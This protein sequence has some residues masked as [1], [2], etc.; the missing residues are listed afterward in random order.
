MSVYHLNRL[1]RPRSVGLVGASPRPGSLGRIV[2]AKLREARFD[3]PV[4][5]VNPKHAEIDGSRTVG[6]ITQL[7]ETPDVVV[8]TAP[9][10]TVPA[11]LSEAGAKGVS[12]AVVISAGLGH[13]PDRWPSRRGRRRGRTGCASWGRTDSA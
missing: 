3:G 10:S 8:V 5:V 11:I 9:A 4:W 7:E 6:S 13:G 12:V 1:F 2:L